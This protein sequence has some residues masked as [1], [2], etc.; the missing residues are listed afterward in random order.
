MFIGGLS[1]EMF[2]IGRVT[3][4]L[5]PGMSWP[6]GWISALLATIACSYLARAFGRLFAQTFDRATDGYDLRA[7][8]R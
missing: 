8:F 1:L 4:K 5:L 6:L 7:A 2:L 3:T